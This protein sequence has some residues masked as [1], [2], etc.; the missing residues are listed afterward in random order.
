M[1]LSENIKAYRVSQDMTLED[2]AKVVGVTRGTIQKY[3]NGII[4]NI[5]SD[6][7]ELLAKALHTTP[8]KL[9]GWEEENLPSN[10]LP[11]PKMVKKPR[12][13][14]IACGKPILAV[15]EAEEFDMVPET[16]DCDFTLR[17]KGDSMINAGIFD[18]D[19]VIVEQTPVA[20]DGDIVV[21]LIDDSATV[22]R[23][24]KENGHYRLQPENDAMEPIIVSDL[25][26]LGK[27]I[28]LFRMM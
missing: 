5:P 24:Y 8:G 28:A 14:T 23:F 27:V 15:E 7:I 9:M 11:L 12:L 4:S 10:V 1:S 2:V 26:I 21:A 17:C 19:R 13:G 18:G 16:M 22:K 25:N 20:T 3:E 6:K